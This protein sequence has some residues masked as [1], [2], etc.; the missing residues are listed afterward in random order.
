MCRKNIPIPIWPIE[1]QATPFFLM[2]YKQPLNKIKKLVK[3]V[4]TEEICMWP[5]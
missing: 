4:G 5:E 2:G 3:G 1:F